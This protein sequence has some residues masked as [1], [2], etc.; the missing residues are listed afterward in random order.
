VT[1]RALRIELTR[2]LAVRALAGDVVTPW[3]VAKPLL[4]EHLPRGSPLF[5]PYAIAPHW[6]RSHWKDPKEWDG[7]ACFAESNFD[8]VLV[9]GG[10]SFVTG[11]CTVTYS[12]DSTLF[13]RAV[14]DGTL[15]DRDSLGISQ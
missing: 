6:W 13:V 1:V 3:K 11:E 8:S 10:L 7:L 15:E 4:V 5:V 12:I 9:H 14:L 2:A